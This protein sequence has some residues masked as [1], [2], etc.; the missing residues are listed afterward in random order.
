MPDAVGFQ[1]MISFKNSSFRMKEIRNLLL[2]T[3]IWIF[4]ISWSIYKRQSL[5]VVLPWLAQAQAKAD[6]DTE[7]FS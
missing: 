5:S 3:Y 1:N 7:K 4:K 6:A 2:L